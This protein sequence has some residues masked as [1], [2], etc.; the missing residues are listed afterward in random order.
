MTEAPNLI[1]LGQK[2]LKSTHLLDLITI[3]VSISIHGQ[4]TDITQDEAYSYEIAHAE[5]DPDLAFD[6]L[7]DDMGLLTT[8][9]YVT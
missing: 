9:L 1:S 5:F 4:K 3:S 2:I 6:Q 8:L 7:L